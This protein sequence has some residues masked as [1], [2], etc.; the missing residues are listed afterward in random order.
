MVKALDTLYESS[1]ELLSG[2]LPTE[3]RG[4]GVAIDSRTAELT[5]TAKLLPELR[6]GPTELIHHISP[7]CVCVFQKVEMFG[8]CQD[9]L[10]RCEEMARQ[11]G[12][13]TRQSLLS[14]FSSLTTTWDLE[15]QCQ[16]LSMVL[17]SLH[18]LS[19]HS[20]PLV[21]RPHTPH[22]IHLSPMHAPPPPPPHRYAKS[23][24][25]SPQSS[26]CF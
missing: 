16:Q 9:I 14:L 11:T 13:A 5:K 18:N 24:K 26:C 12:S 3:E 23:L 19:L 25:I 6:V 2:G 15:K 10:R 21:H 1:E 7:L 17:S 20:L 4:A 8:R 22:L